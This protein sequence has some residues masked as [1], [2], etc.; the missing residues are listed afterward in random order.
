MSQLNTNTFFSFYKHLYFAVFCLIIIFLTYISKE[1][2]VS[3][4]MYYTTLGEQLSYDSIE[5]MLALQEKWQWV[6]YIV[7]PL[8]YLLKFSLI[9][10]CLSIGAV[11]GNQKVSFKKLFHIVM[12]A[13]A[14][15]L[16][17]AII[18]IVWFMFIQTDYGLEDLQFF[19]PLSLLSIFDAGTVAQWWLYPL[20]LLNVFE[21]IYWFALAYGLHQV[22]KKSVNDMLGFVLSTYGV[23]LLLWLVMVTFLSVSIS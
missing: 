10:M 14:I 16:L 19:Y 5:K 8:I 23:G 4:E 9:A 21:V 11:L 15:F 7:I 12:I 18:K 1:F 20:Q 2:L 3:E 13:E 17:P 6:G 22:L